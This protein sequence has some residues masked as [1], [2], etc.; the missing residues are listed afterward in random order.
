[1]KHPVFLMPTIGSALTVASAI[2]TAVTYQG[3][4]YE[5]LT[6]RARFAAGM[7]RHPRV[8]VTQLVC[9]TVALVLYVSYFVTLFA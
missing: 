6:L 1:V 7:Q 8:L 4:R 2:L 5:G 9:L 3:R